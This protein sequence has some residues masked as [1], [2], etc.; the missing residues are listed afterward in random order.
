MKYTI[1]IFTENKPG[2][3]YRI[4]DIL[5]RRKINIDS[6]TVSE[7]PGQNRSRFTIVLQTDENEI[8]K[9]TL[10][11]EKIIEV[12]EIHYKTDDQIIFHELALVKIALT[13]PADVE[14]FENYIKQFSARVFDK[15]GK[16]IIIEITGTEKEIIEVLKKISDFPVQDIAVS[17]RTAVFK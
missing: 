15:D 7:I 10:Q 17:G 14:N 9:I 11:L 3:L 12:L 2:V 5:L 4:A 13:T 1:I 6:L 8:E 16:N